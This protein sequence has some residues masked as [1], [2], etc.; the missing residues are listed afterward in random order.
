MLW[1]VRA[2]VAQ[3][4]SQYFEIESAALV[5]QAFTKSSN[6]S[7]KISTESKKISTASE[8]WR[9]QLHCL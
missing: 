8:G 4:S 9:N 3:E 6:V 7:Q 5:S 1:E 2:V